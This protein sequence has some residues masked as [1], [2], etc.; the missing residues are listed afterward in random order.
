VTHHDKIYVADTDNNRIQVFGINNH[1]VPLTV[2]LD[3]PAACQDVTATMKGI[4]L[5]F[6]I[7]G[8]YHLDT[9]YRFEVH[10]TS[11]SIIIDESNG[12]PVAYDLPI[13][14]DAPNP[15]ASTLGLAFATHDSDSGV[16]RFSIFGSDGSHTSL[17]FNAP[18]CLADNTP[19]NTSINSAIDSHNK[20]V[21]NGGL[22]SSDS[23]TFS[24]E[25]TDNEGIPVYRNYCF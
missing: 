9:M 3:R 13:P 16:F 8:L 22:S 18:L 5:R 1:I 10:G 19:P 7:T 12:V 20:N 2:N 6:T 21:E 11:G 4:S 25:G 17:D 24:F 15:A 14:D 23:I